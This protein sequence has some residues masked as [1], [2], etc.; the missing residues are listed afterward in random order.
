MIES[1]RNGRGIWNVRAT[2]RWQI[3]SGV[4]PAI[5]SPWKRMDPA[6]GSRAPEMQLNIVVL[7][8]PLGPMSPRISPSTT[9]K[10]MLLSAVKPPKRLTTPDTRSMGVTRGAGP[11]EGGRAGPAPGPAKGRRRG[12]RGPRRI[13]QRAANGEDAGR[14]T[15]GL[16]IA[17][18]LGQTC[19]NRPSTIW[20]T[21]AMARSFCPRIGF[22]SPRNFTP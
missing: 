18:T 19:W 4:S 9:S 14:I 5:S 11:P 7:P 16:F 8:E 10:E 20:Y 12:P 15:G 2:P 22:P 17:I 3:A 6:V 13:G 1:F 21:A